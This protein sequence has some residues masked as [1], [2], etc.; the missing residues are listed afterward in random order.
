MAFGLGS[1]L[2][3]AIVFEAVDKVSTVV[4]N[5]QKKVD[6]LATKAEKNTAALS[7]SLN[8]AGNI[9]IGA[10]AAVGAAL[11][12][13]TV[14]ATRFQ[15]GM[16]EV[17]TL[18]SGDV[19]RK[20]AQYGEAVK[21]LSIE[22]GVS[23]DD[24]T[25]G[26]YQTI[27]AFGEVDD[28]TKIL[29]I[30]TKAAAAGG[31]TVK[32][33]IDLLSAAAKG[34]GD[35]SAEMN[36][37]IADLAFMTVK[38]GQ[39]TFPELASSMGAVVPV[40]AQMGIEIEELFGA[41]ATLTGVTGSTAEVSTQLRSAFMNLLKPTE[42]MQKILR[43]LGY[44]SGTQIVQA[45]G[46]QGALVKLAK[47]AEEYNVDLVE[48]F[49][50]VRALPAVLAL[51]GPQADVM[52]KKTEQMY[53][54]VGAAG[55]AFEKT[56]A[57]FDASIQQ[58]KQN[59]IV[60]AVSV[61]ETIL[62]V[63][64]DV[65]Q[66]IT[67]FFSWINKLSPGM[68]KFVGYFMLF[69][70]VGLIAGGALL[71][72]V[73]TLMLIKSFGMAASLSLGSIVWPILAIAGAIT[74]VVLIIKN[75]GKITAWLKKVWDGFI[76]WM[77]KALDGIKKAVEAVLGFFHKIGEGIKS[78]SGGA[79]AEVE[80]TTSR[81]VL[82][83]FH[84]IGKGIKSIFGGARAEVE[85]TT[86]RLAAVSGKV[87]AGDM[88]EKVS[89]SLSNVKGVEGI[90]RA[91]Q[92]Q[93]G[94]SLEQLFLMASPEQAEQAGQALIETIAQGIDQRGYLLPGTLAKILKIVDEYLPHS[95]AKRGP[96]S[97]LG[98]VGPGLISTITEGIV[99]SSP[100]LIK[101]TEG[102]T[103][104][105]RTA[106][107]DEM[108]KPLPEVAKTFAKNLGISDMFDTLK[109]AWEGFTGFLK[110]QAGQKL[111]QA[112]GGALSNAVGMIAS[113]FGG[114]VA[115]QIAQTAM[116]AINAIFAVFG[117]QPWFKKAMYPFK[118]ELRRAWKDLQKPFKDLMQALSPLL[119]IAGKF[120]AILV[121]IGAAAFLKPFIR[122]LELVTKLLEPILTPLTDFLSWLADALD[123][124]LGVFEGL[125]DIGNVLKTILTIMWNALKGIFSVVKPITEAV[126]SFVNFVAKI[127]SAVGGWVGG[128]IRGILGKIFGFAKGGL[129][130]G[131]GTSTSDNIL[132]RLSPGE[133]VVN[134]EATKQYLPLLQAIN[135]G[136]EPPV[137]AAGPVNMTIHIHEATNPRE[138]VRVIKE[139]LARARV[140]V[141]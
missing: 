99:E 113:V 42:A 111:D 132:A 96:L 17:G 53:K 4:D 49:P 9:M 62:P 100:K 126:G 138:V 90:Y 35:V 70:S 64:Q 92:M 104:K 91:I 112:L 52:T 71:K 39:T 65:V 86:S 13:A 107:Q 3:L 56:Q 141:G 124:I 136:K 47:A 37:K 93:Y 122:S 38:L 63:L 115:G 12:G 2:E 118:S 67:K 51:V 139:E 32:D 15:K 5:I 1:A 123:K 40:A 48:L 22:T 36:Q 74:A 25:K 120:L 125:T 20:L 29:E 116:G 23:L 117:K 102:V 69:G 59:L 79:R 89:E 110:S 57:T 85:K 135:E 66:G 28:A 27:S 129:V 75:W 128:I 31:S 72:I 127:L 21:K 24:L 16:A 94:K 44:E 130:Q 8:K 121:K 14:Q 78:I 109:G 26:L 137:P 46:L 114:P 87:S 30:A 10:G 88:W 61:G 83:F 140:A 7:R 55:E 133:F 60:L 134:A 45:E 82:G 34:Y 98:E 108:K 54:A 80:K 97:T 103:A 73:S 101:T 11:V 119:Q 6:Q 58:L 95:P 77:S 68:R 33:A 18:L 81:A 19:S 50:N 106:F 131:P 84:K 105:L 43:R 76:G 41:Y